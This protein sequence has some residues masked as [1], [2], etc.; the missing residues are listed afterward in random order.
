GYKCCKEP[1]DVIY[2]DVDGDWGA[3]N[4]EWCGCGGED[5]EISKDCPESIIRIGYV[6]CD[7]CQSNYEDEFGKW[8]HTNN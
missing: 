5:F 4:N 2:T 1:C 6:C 3:E 7:H 8:Y